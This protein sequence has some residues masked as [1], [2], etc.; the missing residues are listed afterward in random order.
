MSRAISGDV[1]RHQRFKSHSTDGTPCSQFIFYSK[2]PS[3]RTD[4]DK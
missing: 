4:I 1:E 2:K 3:H